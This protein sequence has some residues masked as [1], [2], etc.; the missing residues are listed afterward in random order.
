MGRP[1]YRAMKNF[2]DAAQAD[3]DAMLDE[4]CKD[5]ARDV[6]SRRYIA[7]RL[8]EAAQHKQDLRHAARNAAAVVMARAE[9]REHR[10]NRRAVDNL[11][12]LCSQLGNDDR[13]SDIT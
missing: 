6:E 5:L 10:L 11:D 4:I 1:N 7:K 9:L 12:Q 3:I 2:Y 8:T 13:R